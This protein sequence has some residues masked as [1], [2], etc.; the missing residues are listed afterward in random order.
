MNAIFYLINSA[1]DLLFFIIILQVIISWLIAFNI[2]NT[3]N[4]F[5]GQIIFFLNR[6]TFPL[7]SPIKKILPNLGP[8]DISPVIVLILLKVLQV[9]INRD[10][11]PFLFAHM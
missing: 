9:Y 5:I 6:I 1:I 10:L 2:L 8:I 7:L 11:K 3:Y 4:Q